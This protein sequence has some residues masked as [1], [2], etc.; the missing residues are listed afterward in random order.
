MSHNFLLASADTTLG[1]GTQAAVA[2]STEVAQQAPAQQD[3][4]LFGGGTFTLIFMY[5]AIFAVAW[6]FIIR[7]QRKRQKAQS[8]MQSALQVGDS[9]MTNSGMYGKI[10]DMGTDVY[11]IE[12]GTAKGVRIPVA[13]SEIMAKKEPSLT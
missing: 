6:M 12:F 5:V 8:E 10:V 9:I 13:K 7:P 11:V 3:A 4:G 2:A 1:H